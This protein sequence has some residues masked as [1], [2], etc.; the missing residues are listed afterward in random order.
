M[1]E[2]KAVKVSGMPK[3]SVRR[4]ARIHWIPYL[5]IAPTVLLIVS[6]L[7]YPMLNVFYFSLQN[8]NPSKPYYNSFAGLDNF[9]KIFT[10]FAPCGR[11]VRFCSEVHGAGN[12]G[13]R[14]QRLIFRVYSL[15][16]G[17]S[18]YNNK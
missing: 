2:A 6:F 12:G 4:R 15:P 5:F 17:S 16:K 13:R 1:M 8:Y 14:G 7:F 3:P 9:V 11:S 18:I 10:F